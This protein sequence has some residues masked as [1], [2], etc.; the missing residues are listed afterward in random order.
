MNITLKTGKV[1]Q[2]NEVSDSEIE[3]L[4]KDSREL[5]LSPAERM[6]LQVPDEM[7]FYQKQR[8]CFQGHLMWERIKGTNLVTKPERARK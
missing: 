8:P 4:L 5:W 6:E 7:I 1:F 2:F 3:E